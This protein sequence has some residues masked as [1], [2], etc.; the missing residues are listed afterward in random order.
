M[1]TPHAALE[2][3]TPRQTN[4]RAIEHFFHIFASKNYLL[5]WS[6][7]YFPRMSFEKRNRACVFDSLDDVLVSEFRRIEPVVRMERNPLLPLRRA[8]HA[9]K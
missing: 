8:R 5:L 7:D 1:K 4:I 9:T 3:T 2:K 6:S